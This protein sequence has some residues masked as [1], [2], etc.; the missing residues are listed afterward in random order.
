MCTIHTCTYTHY[1]VARMYERARCRH[2]HTNTHTHKHVY[3]HTSYQLTRSPISCIFLFHKT[4]RC[5]ILKLL[6]I[7]IAITVFHRANLHHTS[8]IIHHTSHI[9]HHTSHITHHTSHIIHHVSHIIL[10]ESVA[11]QSNDS[12]HVYNQSLSV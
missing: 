6:I 2:T 11:R 5:H 4:H 10:V 7:H 12:V 9:T 3:A 1:L 8:H